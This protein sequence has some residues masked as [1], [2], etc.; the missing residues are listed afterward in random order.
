MTLLPNRQNKL[1][2]GR[3]RE[4]DC[5][6]RR[7]G[8][9]RQDG[10]PTVSNDSVVCNKG[11]GRLVGTL[12]LLLALLATLVGRALTGTAGNLG[13]DLEEDLAKSRVVCP[14]LRHH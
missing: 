8:G 1:R 2:G 3:P 13:S 6:Q 9:V 5:R 4:E 10:Q 14:R 11:S 7:I 12:A